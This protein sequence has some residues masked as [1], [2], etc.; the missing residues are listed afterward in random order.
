MIHYH[1]FV[2]GSAQGLLNVTRREVETG[3]SAW[4]ASATALAIARRSLAMA[5]PLFGVGLDVLPNI[6]MGFFCS[7]WWRMPRACV[8]ERSAAFEGRASNFPKSLGHVDVVIYNMHV[9]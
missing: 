8:R 9:F 5:S 3:N 2:K 4:R 7:T 1:A 6:M